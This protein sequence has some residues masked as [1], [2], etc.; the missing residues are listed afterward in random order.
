MRKVLLAVLLL[1]GYVAWRI[2]KCLTK[3]ILHLLV[4]GV[5]L[6][7]HIAHAFVVLAMGV[8]TLYFLLWLGGMV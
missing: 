3:R 1:I 4:V 8:V 2:I 5:A 6:P 7:L